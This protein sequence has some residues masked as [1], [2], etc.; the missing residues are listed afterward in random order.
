MRC[1]VMP[2]IVQPVVIICYGLLLLLFHCS[3]E[4]ICFNCDV[5]LMN[6][7]D[8]VKLVLAPHSLCSSCFCLSFLDVFP[9]VI[10]LL[11]NFDLLQLI[12]RV[13]SLF[14]LRLFVFLCL[15][16]TVFCHCGRLWIFLFMFLD[17]L[18][19][20]TNKYLDLSG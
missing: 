3:C 10:L 17:A 4:V 11:L 8:E 18:F 7:R 19:Q 14:Y 13:S 16:L 2:I 6:I 20:V 1:V 5:A 9:V 12:R 15:R